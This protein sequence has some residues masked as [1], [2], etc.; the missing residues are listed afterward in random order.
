MTKIS[1]EWF[2]KNIRQ[3]RKEQGWTQKDF[4][5]AIGIYRAALG[6]IE[7]DQRNVRLATAV[8]CAQVLDVSIDRLVSQPIDS[9]QTE[10]V[11]E[12][13]EG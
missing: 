1:H 3:L 12:Q 10:D 2:G 9:D 5:V 6:R 8:R 4:A 11:M 7:M 13:R